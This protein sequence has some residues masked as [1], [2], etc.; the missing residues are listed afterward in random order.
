MEDNPQ[1]DDIEVTESPKNQTT[2]GNVVQIQKGTRKEVFNMEDGAE[3]EYGELDDEYLVFEIETEVNG[4]EYTVRE[5]IRFYDQPSDRS[6]FG[7]FVKR[8][9]QP[10]AGMTVT[11]DFDEEGETDIVL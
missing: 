7:K 11:V 9:G 4:T 6:K 1:L 3:P 8:Y 5:P 2:E 10:E